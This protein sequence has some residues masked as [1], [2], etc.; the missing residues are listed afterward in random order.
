[1]SV[2][3][4]TK[5]QNGYTTAGAAVSRSSPPHLI[6]VSEEASAL[7]RQRERASSHRAESAEVTKTSTCES[8]GFTGRD[9]QGERDGASP[10]V[11]QPM[12]KVVF[13]EHIEGSTEQFIDVEST[14]QEEEEAWHKGADENTSRHRHTQHGATKEERNS[15]SHVD[16]STKFP[17][18]EHSII[19]PPQ[20]TQRPKNLNS[21]PALVKKA[22][23]NESNAVSQIIQRVQPATN[24]LTKE[25]FTAAL[26]KHQQTLFKRTE[27]GCDGLHRWNNHTQD[28]KSAPLPHP[29]HP[30]QR[31]PVICS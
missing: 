19:S 15:K 14:D 29:P 22:G 9:W 21:P 24:D 11:V 20:A 1:M 28:V 7:K 23:D 10:N 17:S 30:P 16:T 8:N 27:R 5:E 26:K 13:E 6:S 2:L 31:T 4:Y 12:E 25:A 18:E 3:Q